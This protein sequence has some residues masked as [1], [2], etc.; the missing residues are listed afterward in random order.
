MVSNGQTSKVFRLRASTFCINPNLERRPELLKMETARI[1]CV[2]VL[3]WSLSIVLS[4]PAQMETNSQPGG[5]QQ[6]GGG[7][8][9]SQSIFQSINDLCRGLLNPDGLS[10]LLQQIIQ[11]ITNI[12]RSLQPQQLSAV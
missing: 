10:P 7:T 9:G 12:M 1:C 2:S 11:M 8:A 3:I 5:N 4:H 6:V